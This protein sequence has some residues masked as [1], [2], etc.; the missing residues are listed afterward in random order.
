MLEFIVCFCILGDASLTRI[1]GLE[2]NYTWNIVNREFPHFRDLIK[3]KM[4]ICI[5]AKPRYWK[6]SLYMFE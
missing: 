4:K 1:W 6:D 5:S 3:V 2:K